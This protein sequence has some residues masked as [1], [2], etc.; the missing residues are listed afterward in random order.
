MPDGQVVFEVTGDNKGIKQ[1]LA[2]TTNAIQSEG[3]KW[4]DSAKQA[5]DSME[6]GFA[7]FAKK[8]SAALVAAQIG[9]KLLDFGKQAIAAASDLEEVQNVVDVTFGESASQINDWA[10]SA[11]KQFGLTE[12]QAKRFTST[13]GA[14]AKS[15]GIAQKDLVSMSENLAGLAADMA[16]FYNLDFETAF[17]KIRSGISGE[18]E[19]LKALGINMSVANLEAFALSQ[20]IDKAF[21]S[22]SQGEQTMLRYQYLMQATADAQGDFARTSDGYA[23]G[24]RMLETNIE[25]L[26]TNI[27]KAILPVVTSV[28][29]GINQMF[30]AM[31]REPPKKTV[32]DTFADIDLKTEEKIAQIRATADEAEAT[33]EALEKVSGFTAT[34]NGM[35]EFVETLSGHFGN[36]DEAL[37]KAKSADYA[38][39]IKSIGDALELDTGK[40]SDRWQ[41]LLNAIA[42]NLPKAK[43]AI[44]GNGTNVTDFLSAA[45]S[46]AASLGGEYPAL[47]AS[48]LQTLGDDAPA[49][50]QALA[51]GAEGAH[52]MELFSLAMQNLDA[53][54]PEVIEKLKEMG[55]SVDEYMGKQKQWA[56]VSAELERI[57]PGISDV[58]NSQKGDI[59]GTTTA[60]RDYVE[61]W[62]KTQEAMA[63][64]DAYYKKRDALTQSGSDVYSAELEMGVAEAKA[65]QAREALAEVEAKYGDIITQAAENDEFAPAE[66]LNA[67]RTASENAAKATQEAADAR[68]NYTNQVNA[69]AQALEELGLME[70]YI[71]EKTGMSAEA[72][73]ESTGAV[74]ENTS[75][76]NVN[77]ESLQ[78]VADALKAVSDYYDQ[79][80][81]ETASQVSKTL[82]G[83]DQII[84]PMEAAMSKMEDLKQQIDEATGEKQIKLTF[85]LESLEE[86]IPSI[87]NMIQGLQ[88]QIDYVSEYQSNLAAAKAKG[89]SEE[90]LATLSDG[91]TQSADYL[92]VLAE[93]SK[94]EIDNLNSKYAEAQSNAQ[95]LTQTLTDQK[96]EADAQFDALVQKADEAVQALDLSGEAGGNMASTI[97]AIASAISDNKDAVDQAVQSIID[98][99]QKLSNIKINLKVTRSFSGGNLGLGDLLNG[100][101][102]TGLDYV[103]FDNFLAQLHEGEGILTAEENRVWQQ[104]KNGGA[105]TANTIDYGTLGDVIHTNTQSGGGNV[106][107][108]GQTVG[109]VIS[110]QQANSLRNLERSGWQA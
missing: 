62:Q 95:S 94:E 75:A 33:I 66:A 27:G 49:A 79:I 96:L 93:A 15:S 82:G 45:S 36:L 52:N 88:D 102:A 97:Q 43:E 28:V 11:G 106:Y 87:Q 57:M 35:S 101:F 20:G 29:A 18:T 80:Y 26:K 84:T 1:V 23:N 4:D 61:Q 108:D 17:E 110:A 22:M 7:S 13:L 91:S 68:Q 100:S 41:T 65:R 103:P 64:W 76:N 71:T 3:K 53:D 98:S 59:E 31:Q 60:L 24:V 104:F 47:W 92:K 72:Y 69:N 38:G 74:E 51:E 12:T 44:D 67:M 10:K 5:T 77:A 34:S 99:V 55:V 30:D 85:Q 70:E 105:S 83:F 89:A 54:T 25:S 37:S 32:L 109:R 48:L 8:A 40:N 19:P 107:L 39:T 78:N 56:E 63:L 90:L 50:L 86:T 16:S 42:D 6:S 21:S 2:D 46:A 58:L 14:M 81:S 9:E 73:Q